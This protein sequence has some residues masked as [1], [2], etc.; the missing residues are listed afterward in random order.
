MLAFAQRFLGALLIVDV[1]YQQVPPSNIPVSIAKRKTSVLEPAI[2]TVLSPESHR[3]LI[4]TASGNRSGKGIDNAR[5]ILRV[6]Q[7]RSFPTP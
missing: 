4:R 6:D 2:D 3:E 5:Q 1:G 7:C